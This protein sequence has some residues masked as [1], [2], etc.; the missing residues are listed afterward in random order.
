M[1]EATL[2][3]A[4][5]SLFQ[6]FKEIGGSVDCVVLDCDTEQEVAAQ[7]S[8]RKAAIAGLEVI[9][10]RRAAY[11]AKTPAQQNIPT[12]RFFAMRIDHE[13]AGALTGKRISDRAF[14]GAG[15]DYDR[16][17]LVERQSYSE[18]EGYAYSFSDPP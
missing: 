11:A 8:H 17:E 1:K 2:S 12:G 18:P 6:R 13:K 7:E 4:Q 9:A 5:E 16:K 10:K 3:Q 15:H 14:L